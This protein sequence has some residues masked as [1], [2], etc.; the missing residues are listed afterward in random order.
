MKIRDIVAGPTLALFLIAFTIN[1]GESETI[2]KIIHVNLFYPP[3]GTQN[4]HGV[5]NWYYYWKQGNVV[6]G[7]Q[8]FEYINISDCGQYDPV[9]DILYVGNGAH[10]ISSTFTVTNQFTG[11]EYVIGANGSG[12]DCCAITCAHE[13]EH[14]RLA[15]RR[16]ENARREPEFSLDSDRDGISNWDEENTYQAYHLN[17]HFPDTY[18]MV[19]QDG[20]YGGTGDEEFIAFMA[21]KNTQPVD[22]SADWSCDGKNWKK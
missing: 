15:I 4:G 5:P 19:G 22:S 17:S 8:A 20:R 7:L 13:K 16:R 3:V 14:L 12:I 6:M 11:E 18:K 1:T 2:E 10:C 21:E 9:S